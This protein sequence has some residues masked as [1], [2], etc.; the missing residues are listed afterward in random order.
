MMM[1]HLHPL[2]HGRWFTVK[3]ITV[4]MPRGLC[5]MAFCLIIPYV[6]PQTRFYLWWH[7]LYSCCCV[8]ILT[9]MIGD[10]IL[11]LE[12]IMVAGMLL[13]TFAYIHLR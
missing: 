12:M 11:F 6:I 1:W 7:T 13:D 10:L 9:I 4:D 2:T 5:F 8:M 3:E